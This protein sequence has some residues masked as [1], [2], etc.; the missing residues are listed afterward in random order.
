M[1]VVHYPLTQKPR[2]RQE[3]P[4]VGFVGIPVPKGLG[5][6]EIFSPRALG[7]VADIAKL[8]HDLRV[9][10]DAIWAALNLQPIR[11]V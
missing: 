6:V 3:S 7:S 9:E 8:R 10:L 5:H 1:G 4:Q 11:K 2:R